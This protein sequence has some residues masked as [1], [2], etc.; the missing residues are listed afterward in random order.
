MTKV[1]V[2]M[3]AIEFIKP[4]KDTTF[5]MLVAA[6]TKGWQIYYMQQHDL[7]LQDG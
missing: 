5:A 6:P 3:D 2:V 7:F 4:Y 1:G